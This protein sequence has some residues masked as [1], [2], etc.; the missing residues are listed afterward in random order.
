MNRK[1]FISKKEVL[2]NCDKSYLGINNSGSGEYKLM[3]KLFKSICKTLLNKENEIIKFNAYHQE[4][5]CDF[6]NIKSQNSLEKTV[7][8]HIHK[9]MSSGKYV[10]EN[11]KLNIDFDNVLDIVWCNYPHETVIIYILNEI[12]YSNVNQSVIYKAKMVKIQYETA[13]LCDGNNTNQICEERDCVAKKY[14]MKQ[15][16][17]TKIIANEE[18]F[19]NQLLLEE[20]NC[21]IKL[22][23]FYSKS[24]FDQYLIL[25]VVD[26]NLKEY[27]KCGRVSN[28]NKE[29]I[30]NEITKILLMLERNYIIHCDIKESNFLISKDGNNVKICDFGNAQNEK[31]VSNPKQCM[32]NLFLI[33]TI[34]YIYSPP[35]SRYQYY[36]VNYQ[37]DVWCYALLLYQ[38]IFEE[39]VYHNFDNEIGKIMIQNE[40]NVVLKLWESVTNEMLK[41]IQKKM[42]LIQIDNTLSKFMIII[43]EGMKRYD[44]NEC[45]KNDNRRIMSEIYYLF[46]P[47]FEK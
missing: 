5:L 26:L 35:E 38:I 2:I 47:I 46:Q 11:L 19:L 21:Y 12:V 20:S 7:V 41:V 42:A 22:I 10:V 31:D 37:Y 36:R 28:V 3:Y 15:E 4:L 16:L 25:E 44:V 6:Q 23:L 8:K 34:K 18:K 30:I 14:L 32:N 24:I 33:D 9:I 29:F 1:N 13:F 45:K 27:L 43:N 17:A 40:I 39:S